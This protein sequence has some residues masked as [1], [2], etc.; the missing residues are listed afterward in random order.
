[1]GRQRENFGP[2]ICIKRLHVHVCN[3]TE[4]RKDSQ[5]GNSGFAYA[6]SG[7]HTK[8]WNCITFAGS[9]VQNIVSTP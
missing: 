9:C 7:R 3:S 2:G 4:V 5:P 8:R 6:K 1:M